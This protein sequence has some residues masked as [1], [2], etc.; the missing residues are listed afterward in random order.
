MQPA[1]E[2]Q[3]KEALG[4]SHSEWID[5]NTVYSRVK[6]QTRNKVNKSYKSLKQS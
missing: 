3:L 5:A 6:S 2:T 1:C 4:I